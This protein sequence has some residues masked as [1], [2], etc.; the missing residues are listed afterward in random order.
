MAHNLSQITRVYPA[1]KRFD[2][3]N[4]DPLVFWRVGCQMVALNYQTPCIN[5]AV[6]N[7]MF[8]HNQRTG[9]VDV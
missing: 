5:M 9:Y 2:S 8:R 6:H 1:G 3:S 7:A 4:Y